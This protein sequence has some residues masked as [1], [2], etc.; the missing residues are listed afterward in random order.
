MHEVTVTFPPSV[1]A[2]AP[3]YSPAGY[4]HDPVL[5]VRSAA[6]CDRFLIVTFQQWRGTGG[7]RRPVLDDGHVR[8]SLLDGSGRWGPS[9][10]WLPVQ[11]VSGG[12]NRLRWAGWVAAGMHGSHYVKARAW[13][14]SGPR[15][16]SAPVPIT[17]GCP[18]V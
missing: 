1:V 7:A 8:L 18:P 10:E 15:A 3:S 5:E 14:A 2:L 4:A 16:V 9:G 17:V 13:Q 12:E 6:V 11:A